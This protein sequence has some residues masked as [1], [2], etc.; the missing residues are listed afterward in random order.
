MKVNS[1]YSQEL[2]TNKRVVAYLSKKEKL[3]NLFLI[4]ISL[5]VVYY[6]FMYA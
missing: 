5:Y 4:G 6:I 3:V 1:F 2:R